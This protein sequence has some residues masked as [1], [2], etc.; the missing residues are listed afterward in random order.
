MQISVHLR[1]GDNLTDM[2]SLAIAK[3]LSYLSHTVQLKTRAENADGA[4]LVIQTGFGRSV[5]LLSAI[6]Q[7]IPYLIMEAPS[8]RGFYDVSL[9]S[10]FT[11]N[12]LQNGGTR[13]EPLSEVRRSPTLKDIQKGG[14]TLILAQKPTDHS[15]RGSDHISWLEEVVDEFPDAQFRHHPIMVPEDYQE[16]IDAALNVCG[17]TISYTSTAAVDSLI[18]GCKTIC[19][20]P[21]NEAYKVTDREEWLHKL[22]WCNFTHQEYETD[23][24]AAYVLNGYDEALADAEIGK[25][26]IPRERVNGSAV[27]QRYYRTFG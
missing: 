22:S 4:D 8:F 10:V 18:A 17:R 7:E 12:G 15:L 27:C 13:P 20:H 5:A 26:E 23:E 21:S 14:P 25:Q 16:S 19:R 2:R 9:A 24:V 1:G 6:E 3:G 11:Y